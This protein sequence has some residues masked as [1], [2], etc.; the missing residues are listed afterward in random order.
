MRDL[1]A[2]QSVES[3]LRRAGT[4]APTPPVARITSPLVTTAAK[5]RD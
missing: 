1:L 4:F 2:L 5:F 3:Q